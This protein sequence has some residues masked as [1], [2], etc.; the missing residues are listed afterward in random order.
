MTDFPAPLPART[1]LVV[2]DE[3][4]IRLA[5]TYVLEAAGYQVRVAE[6]GAA[7]LRIAG[8]TTIDAALID[9]HMPR[10]NGFETCIALR[11]QCAGR[12]AAL[13]V[14][15][16]SGVLTKAVAA[17]AAELGTLGTFRK[18]FDLPTLLSAIAA[19]FDP[20]T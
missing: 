15:F 12:G 16:M 11:A 5:L 2:D 1:V 18:P 20:P 7:A 10:M 4:S 3:P 9:L 6:S 14:W 17:R 19:A 13:P 8:E